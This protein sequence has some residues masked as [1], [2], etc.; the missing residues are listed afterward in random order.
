MVN[1]RVCMEISPGSI[2]THECEHCGNEAYTFDAVA[3]STE[4]VAYVGTIARCYTCEGT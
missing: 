1:E 4:G 3:L 2:R